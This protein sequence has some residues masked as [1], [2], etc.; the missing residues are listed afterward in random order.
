MSIINKHL[1]ILV[2]GIV[3]LIGLFLWLGNSYNL[4]TVYAIGAVCDGVTDDTSAINSALSS[5]ATHLVLPSGNCLVSATISVP[6]NVWL[7]GQGVGTTSI[8]T[9]ANPTYPIIQVVGNDSQIDNLTVNG[10]A[11]GTTARGSDGIDV[12]PTYGNTKIHNVEV[13]NI[14]DDG[15]E[16]NGN[17][18]DIYDNHLHDIYTNCI[19]VIGNSTNTANTN[20]IHN[21][22]TENCSKNSSPAFNWDGIDIDP[23]SN[24]NAVYD[25]IVDGN[26]IIAYGDSSDN[27]IGTHIYNNLVRNSG[28]NGIN[29]LGTVSDVQISDN[30]IYMPTGYGIVLNGGIHRFMIANNVILYP[31]LNGIYVHGSP[32]PTNGSISDNLIH[33]PGSVSNASD[34]IIVASSASNISIEGNMISD[35]RSPVLIQYS[36]D[37]NGAG[38]DVGIVANK[39]KAGVTGN[40][41]TK[42]GQSVIDNF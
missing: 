30:H 26:D 21:N 24:D 11:T 4:S 37:T 15:I 17:L 36:I 14:P 28:E 19:Y 27:N 38:T 8:F 34:G 13:E 35:T 41:H 5:G 10:N 7:E 12:A 9:A 29:V 6:S 31:T 16:S 39:T 40:L 18:V 2:G 1:R 25:N 42:A 32:S 20:L 22:H 3:L 33:N 23:Y